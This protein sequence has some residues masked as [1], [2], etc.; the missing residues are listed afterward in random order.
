MVVA[1]FACI[2]LQPLQHQ[3]NPDTFKFNMEGRSR[4]QKHFFSNVPQSQ[5][6][7]KS[8]KFFFISASDKEHINIAL[9]LW[10]DQLN[11]RNLTAN[12]WLPTNK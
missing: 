12:M 6:L 10:M 8:F 1:A 9:R 7:R 5:P 2:C 3:N 4:L 11:K